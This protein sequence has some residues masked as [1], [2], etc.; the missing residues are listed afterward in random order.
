MATSTKQ[1]EQ[2]GQLSLLPA[3]W[4]PVDWTNAHKLQ[5][6]TLI[7]AILALAIGFGVHITLEQMG[8]IMAVVNAFFAL[9]GTATANSSPVVKSLKRAVNRRKAGEA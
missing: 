4:N 6:V 8:L 1:K 9:F 5:L 2:E 3:T 7:N